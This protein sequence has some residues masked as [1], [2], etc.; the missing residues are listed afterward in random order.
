MG[1][2]VGRIGGRVGS[3]G[4]VGMIGGRVGSGGCVAGGWFVAVGAGG[5]VAG[6][7][8]GVLTTLGVLVGLGVRVG[9]GGVGDGVD[10][11]LTICS[12]A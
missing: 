9:K 5:S 11:E 10:R 7:A 1:G 6:G 3:G 8:V 12:S 4:S 2:R